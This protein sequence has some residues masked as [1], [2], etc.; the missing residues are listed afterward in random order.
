MDFLSYYV[1]FRNEIYRNIECV[2]N[3][4]V[5]KSERRKSESHKVE[6]RKVESH[7]VESHKVGKAKVDY[8]KALINPEIAFDIS[9]A[10]FV[11]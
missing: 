8:D 2:A 1:N 10:L 11:R 7:K 4:K 9:I 3:V 5:I 6:S